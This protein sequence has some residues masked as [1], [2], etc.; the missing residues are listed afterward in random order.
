MI[1]I[2]CPGSELRTLNGNTNH[3][4]VYHCTLF[5]ISTIF[6]S[7]WNKCLKAVNHTQNAA[8]QSLSIQFLLH[9]ITCY[10]KKEKRWKVHFA[11]TETYSSQLI[12]LIMQE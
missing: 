7:Q 2:Y 5:T 8:H 9:F 4:A 11:W 6:T 3:I 10:G 1:T 12:S